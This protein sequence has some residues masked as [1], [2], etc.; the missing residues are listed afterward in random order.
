VRLHLGMPKIS[1][2]N[3][4]CVITNFIWLNVV[5]P[6]FL[7]EQYDWNS[8]QLGG[9]TTVSITTVSIMT[10]SIKGFYVTLSI[11]DTQHN[12]AL[13]L[14]W[15]SFYYYNYP[16]CHY[17][18]CHYTECRG[19]IGGRQSL[20]GK[21]REV[22]LKGKDQYGWPPCTYWFWSAPF[23]ENIIDMFYKTSY[24]NE[25]VNCT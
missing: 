9:A 2:M 12:N 6:Y 24:L 16:E 17:A 3:F 19:S 23:N 14:C 7:F 10:V 21:C 20:R 8:N 5:S 22:F 25:E 4:P 11:N 18:E 15:V 13:P 1:V